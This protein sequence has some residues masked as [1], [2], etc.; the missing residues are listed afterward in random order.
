MFPSA[1]DVDLLPYAS[2][3]IAE[4]PWKEAA[5]NCP[6]CDSPNTKF[7]YYNNYS[8]AQ[9]RY[10]CKSC[11]RYWT[12]GG[13]LRNV[14]VG[15]GCR[16][17]RRTK[18]S[19]S[20]SSSSSTVSPPTIPFRRPDLM[21]NDVAL[22]SD[23]ASASASSGNID[24]EALYAKYTS[25]RPPDLDPVPPA[26]ATSSESSSRNYQL[27]GAQI[28]QPP[29]DCD[30]GMLGQAQFEPNFEFTSPILEEFE[31]I[32]HPDFLLNGDDW[33]SLEAFYKY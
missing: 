18:S 6:R 28:A 22:D 33:S 15:G 19:S 9:P 21:L 13:S 17:N 31:L 26:V 25:Q 12:K 1:D 11:R 14:P 5:P 23:S 24:L 3:P 4:R 20:S 8:L 7:C 2:R 30:G 16:K 29:I 10:F 27:G 32:H